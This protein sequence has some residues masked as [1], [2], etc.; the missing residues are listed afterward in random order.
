MRAPLNRIESESHC[1]FYGTETWRILAV[2]AWL[3]SIDGGQ[4]HLSKAGIL[5][6]G[7]PR[8]GTTLLSKP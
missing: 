2:H 3:E 5:Y 1:L 7:R 6:A 8:P 4:F